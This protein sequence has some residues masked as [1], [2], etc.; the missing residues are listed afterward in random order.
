MYFASD[1]AFRVVLKTHVR[2]VM[3]TIPPPEAVSISHLVSA[4]VQV[5]NRVSI[6]P[7][8]TQILN[9]NKCFTYSLVVG[10]VLPH[11]QQ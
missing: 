4:A 7:A 1:H 2:G 9:R 5:E 10:T 3:R 11:L 8:S 6:Q